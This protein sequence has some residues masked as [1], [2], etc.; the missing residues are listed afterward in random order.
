VFENGA[1]NLGSVGSN[2]GISVEEFRAVGTK[3]LVVAGTPDGFEVGK[4]VAVVGASNEDELGTTMGNVDG[5]MGGSDAITVG[6]VVNEPVGASEVGDT[7]D[8][9][10]SS[11]GA[12]DRVINGASPC[13]TVRGVG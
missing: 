1:I 2:V 6:T 3:L 7:L 11:V 8:G 9:F 4:A 5:A 12:N 10:V 13:S